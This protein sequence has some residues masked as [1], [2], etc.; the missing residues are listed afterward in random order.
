MAKG[1][2]MTRYVCG[3]AGWIALLCCLGPAVVSCGSSGNGSTFD[4]GNDDGAFDSS[5]DDGSADAEGG[6]VFGNPDANGDGGATCRTCAGLGYTCGMNGDGCG[7]VL[8]CGTCT[9]PEYC[10]GAGFSKC[11]TGSATT[12][13]G[14]PVCTPLASCP[15]G[16]NCGEVGD[17]CGGLVKC[18]TCTA[19]AFC[20][21]GG[22]NVCG[23]I[24]GLDGGSSCMPASCTS[25]GFSC[26]AAGDG[27]G[28][29]L[30]C[31]STCPGT[32][33]CGGGGFDK[34]G[35]STTGS[36]DGG[37]ACVKKTCVGLGYTCGYAADGC[38]GL[39]NCGSTC[40]GTEFCG[41]GGFDVC[42]PTSTGGC[43]TG[44]STTIKGFV[45]D[46][47]DN[48]P[49]YNAL[50]YVP[51]GA[52][53]T[54]TTGVNT[55]APVCSCDSPPAF[56]S[57]F[58]GI[59]GSFTLTNIPMGTS[60]TV[61][62]QLGKWQR[63]FS[64]SITSCGTT[65]LKAHLTLP[66]TRVQGNIPRFAIDTGNV[67][68]MEC[69]LL[70]MGID[71]GEFA[72]PVI[73]GGLPTAPQRVH[74]YQGSIVNGGAVIDGNTPTEDA[75]TEAAS[76]MDAYD[77]VLFPCQGGAAQV[78]TGTGHNKTCT[79]GYQAGNGF[80]NTWANLLDYTAAGGRAFTTH[81]HYDLLDGNGSFTGTANWTPNAG[82]A[83]W[84]GP[85]TG[86]INTTN[87]PRGSIL[88]QW[89]N[90]PA[91]YGGTL[92]QIPVSV[93]RNDFSAVNPP[94]QL[95]M[96]MKNPHPGSFPVHYTFDTPF[97]G[98][99]V[100][101]RVVYSDFHVENNNG[102]NGDMFPSECTMG[103]GLTPQEKLL[104]FMLFDL[105]SCVSPPTCTPLTCAAFPTGTCGQQGDGCGGMTPDCLPCAA[106]QTCGGGGV[107]GQC[108]GGNTC[109]P[110]T[111]AQQNITC[112]PAGDG[113]GNALMCGT[114]NAPQTCGGGGV[115]GQCGGIVGC[116]PKTCAQQGIG[117]G[118]AGDGCGNEIMCPA[119]TPP[120]TCGGAGV[121]G[122]CGGGG[123]CTPQTCMQQNVSCGPA[124]D[125]C[126]NLLQCGTC[127]A[128]ATCGGAGISG[129]CGS[130]GTAQ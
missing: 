90:Q 7:H 71:P 88:A 116:T 120:Q 23:T 70:K 47:G 48:L 41:G 3:W 51:V 93:I 114:C 52:V 62:V 35:G 40:P 4:A 109:Q 96:S 118:P 129:Q 82:G 8:D 13:D 100:C 84:Q 61:V 103:G 92:G 57:A 58:T 110:V 79:I 14:A 99:P 108:G 9:S 39:L 80:P 15:T 73:A 59:D 22:F 53:Q 69:V 28:N 106:G 2:T 98:D 77:V 74:M 85:D 24:A 65:T 34:C 54:P 95:W 123:V 26:G 107:A 42:G 43:P 115:A 20:G 105:T 50:V 124:G 121:P 91:V 33:F 60:A 75:L 130:P 122:Q 27:C 66:S 36:P 37:S 67:D 104:E 30:S 49:V 119:C 126:G 89:L 83:G 117:C 76:V 19:P 1:F 6:S 55:A 11:G 25:L 45:Y 29:P 10:G 16:Q 101:G 12:A 128:P 127:V 87:F 21:G 68:T 31:G 112:G 94:A 63:V 113:C 97:G 5:L 102:A 18:G 44:T 56:A 17:G 111:C 38:G 72:N 125:G 32:E 64:E 81:F 78:C 46:P 86:Y